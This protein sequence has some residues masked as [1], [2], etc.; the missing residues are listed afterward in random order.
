MV[1][2]F[3]FSIPSTNFWCKKYLQWLTLEVML[4][5]CYFQR[6][7]LSIWTPKYLAWSTFLLVLWSNLIVFHLFVIVRTLNLSGW[8]FID[9]VCSHLTSASR[10]LGRAVLYSFDLIVWLM[11]FSSAKRPTVNETKR[12]KLLMYT[13]NNSE[14]NT[15][16]CGMPD[17]TWATKDI[18][19]QQLLAGFN[20]SKRIQSV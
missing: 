5:T 4:E 13:K 6:S 16:P 14:Q 8:N 7:I 9:Q 11:Y 12:E 18:A 20:F 1:F 2:K 3:G 19:L 17:V 15:D 10:S